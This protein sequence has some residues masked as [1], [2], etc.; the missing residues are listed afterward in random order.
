MS[1]GISIKTA[2]YGVGSTTVDALAGVTSQDHD[3]VINFTV[4]PSALNVEDPAPGQTKTLNITYTIN[5][6]SQ[7]TLAVKDGGVV[8]IDAPPARTASGL[9]ITKAEY[10]YQGNYTDVTNALQDKVSKGTINLKVGFAAVGIP[11]PN[12]NKQKEL[13]V[14]YK[15]NG[16]PSSQIILDGQTFAV[17]APP[18]TNSSSAKDAANDFSGSIMNALFLGVKTFIILSLILV[19]WEVGKQYSQGASIVLAIAT[20][21]TYGMFPIIIMPI[22][23]FFWRLFVDH[24]VIVLT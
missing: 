17:S 4:T 1:T 7:N 10:G 16:S 3:G 14:E 8:H 13:K 2:T 19:S 5:G 18:V 15:I 20:A 23:I 11:D 6:G 12:P 24:D 22:G 21:M 9:Q